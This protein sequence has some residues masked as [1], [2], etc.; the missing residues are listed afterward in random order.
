MLDVTSTAGSPST[1]GPSVSEHGV[2]TPAKKADFSITRDTEETSSTSS[3]SDVPR[4]DTSTTRLE[5]KP[6][7]DLEGRTSECASQ[8]RPSI[9]MKEGKYLMLCL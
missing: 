1:V 7:G 3:Q 9:L 2:T 6:I 5:D 4:K 8:Q